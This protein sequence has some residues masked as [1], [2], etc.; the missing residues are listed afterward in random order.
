MESGKRSGWV[1]NEASRTRQLPSGSGGTVPRYGEKSRLTGAAP[2]IGRSGL[3]NEPTRRRAGIGH[4]GSRVVPGCG[5]RSKPSSRNVGH[6]GR[7][8]GGF[9]KIT[10]MI[11]AGGCLTNRFIELSICRAE[12]NCVGNWFAVYV[13]AVLNAASGAVT[14]TGITGAGSKIWSTSLSVPPRSKTAPYR[15]IGKVT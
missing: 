8:L 2:I 13:L 3:I 10:P 1:L 12:G 14:A 4:L 9:A 7:L 6:R 11:H 15:A 5:T